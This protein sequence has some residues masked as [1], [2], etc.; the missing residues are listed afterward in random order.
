MW[1]CGLSGPGGLGQLRHTDSG[2][3]LIAF[4]TGNTLSA[5]N[6]SRISGLVGNASMARPPDPKVLVIARPEPPRAS[7]P[8]PPALHFKTSRR[9]SRAWYSGSMSEHPPKRLRCGR[10]RVGGRTRLSDC[11]RRVWY[12][13]PVEARKW[14]VGKYGP[15][16]RRAR[17]EERREYG[18]APPHPRGPRGRAGGSGRSGAGQPP[19]VSLPPLLPLLPPLPPLLLPLLPSQGG[20]PLPWPCPLWLLPPHCTGGVGSAG[21]VV[22]AAA[23][24]AAG[25]AD[26]GGDAAEAAWPM[27]GTDAP[28][29]AGAG[30]SALAFAASARCMASA[31]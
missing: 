16:Q 8:A 11:E 30:A 10:S 25:A 7:R 29:G 3:G 9:V 5:R 22:T 17:D 2:T 14:S 21:G 20:P 18:E 15:G 28:A 6:G 27:N 4:G 31:R 23:G 12:A 24:A 26:G 1:S 13:H 19:W